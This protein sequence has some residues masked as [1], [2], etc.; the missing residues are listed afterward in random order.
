MSDLPKDV[1]IKWYNVARRMQSVSKS[2]G[3]SIVTAKVLVRSDGTPVTWQVDSHVLEPKSLQ[4][5][6]L[7]MVDFE[8]N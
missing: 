8:N 3:F 2:E 6:L 5:A 7:S 4:N 1:Q